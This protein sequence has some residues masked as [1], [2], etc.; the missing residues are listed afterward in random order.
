M[1]RPD[2][3][4]IAVVVKGF[5][6]TG[7]AEKYAVEVTRY[8]VRKGHRVDLYAW[9]A[10]DSLTTGIHY[11]P[12]PRPRF[13]KFSSVL[14]SYSFARETANLISRASYDA[15]LSHERGFCQDL[16]TVHT[17]SYLLGTERFSFLKKLNNIYLS[18]RS[19]LHL[20]LERKQMES[21]WLVPVSS[22][23]KRGIETYYDRTDKIA[24]ATPGVDIDWF[25][26]TWVGS[27]REGARDVD[28]IRS[29]ELVVLFVGS[30][31]KRK[32]LDDLIR[33]IGPGMKL[34][35]VGQGERLGYYRKLAKNSGVLEKVLFKG[36]ADNIR[37]YYAAADVVVLPSLKEAFGMSILEAMACGLPV[38]SSAATG[39]ASLLEDGK[40]GYV[41]Q[42]A[43]QI[44]SILQLLKS[45]DLR[46]TIGKSARLTAEK[47]TWEETASIY[48]DL[49]L[50][51]LR[52]KRDF[53]SS[54]I[55]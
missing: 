12:V 28:N 55:P 43:S 21:S 53:A 3:L 26:P 27:H 15:V 45:A 9:A 37:D 40:N 36:L 6:S 20:W 5:I 48:E 32:G 14:T 47:H 54:F 41:F 11:I 7:G 24:I 22:V 39:V 49:C 31:F 18:P 51:I 38:I 1:M 2:R 19:W 52:E 10:D 44:G 35:V 8:F 16:S 34:M 42:D 30:E 33:A 23:I 29:D 17:F 25:N 46:S 50:K 13:M 4:N